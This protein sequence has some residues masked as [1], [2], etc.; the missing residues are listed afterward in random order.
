MTGVARPSVASR[1]LRVDSNEAVRLVRLNPSQPIGAEESKHRINRD[2]PHPAFNRTQAKPSLNGRLFRELPVRA[3]GSTQVGFR[4]GSGFR[5]GRLAFGL[6]RLLRRLHRRVRCSAHPRLRVRLGAAHVAVA[7][8]VELGNFLL[9]LFHGRSLG[10]LAQRAASAPRFASAGYD[11]GLMLS[12][13][14]ASPCY[15][16]SRPVTPTGRTDRNCV[17]WKYG[18]AAFNSLRDAGSS[19]E[20]RTLRRTSR[21]FASCCSMVCA[22]RVP[23]SRAAQRPLR[24]RRREARIERVRAAA[25]ALRQVDVAEA[26]HDAGL[27]QPRRWF[28]RLSTTSARPSSI[29]LS[30]SSVYPTPS[31]ATASPAT[32]CRI[33]ECACRRSGSPGRARARAL[34]SASCSLRSRSDRTARRSPRPGLRRASRLNCAFALGRGRR[35]ALPRVRPARARSAIAG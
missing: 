4:R 24:I 6:L 3:L 7:V 5:F 15:S 17:G 32:A 10:R 19:F 31:P 2:L 30:S 8:M 12:S 14:S 11:G 26:V 1:R 33:R 25:G 13:C 34:A 27:H 35:L 22:P 21:D 9:Q 29:A 16:L 23:R 18:Y 20:L 28:A